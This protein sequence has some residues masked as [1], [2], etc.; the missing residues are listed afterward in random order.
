MK[1][2]ENETENET[3]IEWE[4]GTYKNTDGWYS[5]HR[6]GSWLIAE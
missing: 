6:Q 5:S 1:V 4:N 3:E 2:T